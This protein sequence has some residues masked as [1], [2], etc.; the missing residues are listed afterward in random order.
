MKPIDCESVCIHCK[1]CYFDGDGVTE[2][3]TCFCDECMDNFGTN[4]GC[5]RFERRKESEQT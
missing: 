5:Y 3:E 4:E 2:P 1:N